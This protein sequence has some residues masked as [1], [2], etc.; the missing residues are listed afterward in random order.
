[1]ANNSRRNNSSKHSAEEKEPTLFINNYPASLC[2]KH[3]SGDKTFTSVSFKYN[4]KWASFIVNDNQIKDST[5]KDGTIIDNCINIVLGKAH[6]SRKIS[7]KNETGSY[8][9]EQM[10]NG[11]IRNFINENRVSAQF[12]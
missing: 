1:M 3:T 12:A 8:N 4:D 10:S 5:R 2:H 6:Q 11:D 7:F 9:T